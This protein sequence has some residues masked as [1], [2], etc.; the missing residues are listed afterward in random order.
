MLEPDSGSLGPNYRTSWNGEKRGKRREKKLS[1]S[2][3]FGRRR[4]TGMRGHPG[5]WG[6]LHGRTEV[7]RTG[8]PGGRTQNGC[9]SSPCLWGRIV[10]STKR[11]SSLNPRN[12]KTKQDF[13]CFTRDEEG[14]T[15]LGTVKWP[16][17]WGG[18]PVSFFI[19]LQVYES[20]TVCFYSLTLKVRVKTTAGIFWSLS[21]VHSLYRRDMLLICFGKRVKDEVRTFRVLFVDME[22]FYQDPKPT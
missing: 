18:V 8:L 14:D 3:T 9:T 4:T 21:V 20:L 11:P 1:A 13:S 7:Q 19:T 15:E 17:V 5:T 22:I 16:C 6:V 10:E 12:C 2:E